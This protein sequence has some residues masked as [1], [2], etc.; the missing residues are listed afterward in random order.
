MKNIL[1]IN[2]ADN[3]SSAK[4][5]LSQTIFENIV[6]YL[7]SKN[8]IKTTSLANGYIVAKEH[9]KYLWA[10]VIIFQFPIYWFSCPIGLQKYIEK[11]Y[12]KNI[13]Y[14]DCSCE[15]GSC[16]CLEGKEY[17][18]SLTWSAPEKAFSASKNT[19]FE[20]K[21]VDEILIALH[22]TQEYCGLKRLPTFSVFGAEKLPDVK[23][24]IE[25]LQIHL[26]G[27]FN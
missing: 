13:F 12:E 3:F 24:Y 4:G 2:G 9:D 15:Y 8:N 18:F 20:G 25:Q 1:V 19:F 14:S 26:N 16:G 7:V 23:K 11:V 17:M 22:K 6:E 5:C 21:N 10:D 27:I